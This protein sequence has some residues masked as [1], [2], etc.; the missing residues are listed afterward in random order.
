MGTEMV[1]LG[2]DE[3]QPLAVQQ[4]YLPSSIHI[5]PFPIFPPQICCPLHGLIQYHAVLS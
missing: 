5:Q 2:I 3:D 1:R 4:W